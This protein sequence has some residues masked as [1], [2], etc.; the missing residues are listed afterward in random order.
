MPSFAFVGASFIGL[1][2]FKFVSSLPSLRL[3]SLKITKMELRYFRE[4]F[5]RKVIY[6]IEICHKLKKTCRY[7][8]NYNNAALKSL[9]PLQSFS[10]TKVL[11]KIHR[12]ELGGDWKNDRSKKVLLKVFGFWFHLVKCINNSNNWVLIHLVS[13]QL[14]VND[15]F[16]RIAIQMHCHIWHWKGHLQSQL[17]PSHWGLV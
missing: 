5:M 14:L 10:K 6:I 13:L 4:Y 15:A 12:C 17:W 16:T 11:V 1:I 3:R 2:K 8:A 7:C 9:K